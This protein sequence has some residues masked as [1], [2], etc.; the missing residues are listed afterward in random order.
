MPTPARRVT[1][2]SI[3]VLATVILSACSSPHAAPS[4]Q[5]TAGRSDA[6]LGGAGPAATNGARPA[7]PGVA[8]GAGA[9]KAAIATA[10]DALP[11]APGF[12]APILASQDPQSTFGLDVDTASYTYAKTQIDGGR[13]PA[14]GAVRP[15]EFVNAFR[16]D[17]P[18]PEGD[19]FTVTTDGAR[20]PGSGTDYQTDGMRL[21]RVGLQTRPDD[22][23][24]TPAVALTFVIDVSGSMGTPGKLDV[25]KEGL[26]ALVGSLRPDDS[27]AIVTFNASAHVI[28]PATYAAERS[29]LLSAIDGLHAAGR[30]NLAVGLTTG[31]RVARAGFEPE[32]TN[33]VVILSD[34]LA[35][36][37]QTSSSAIVSQV[38]AEADKQITLLGVGVGRTYGDALMESL[39]DHA[40]GFVVYVSSASQARQVFIDQLAATST[41]RALDA[42]AQVTFDP[43]AVISYRLIGYDD[44]AVAD[45]SF[46]DDRVDGGEVEAG[47]QVTAVYAVQLQPQAYGVVATVAVHWVDPLTHAPRD[48][49]S[50]VYADQLDISFEQAAAGLHVCYAAAY[51][52]EVLRGS[53]YGRDLQLD[54]LAAIAGEAAD[55]TEDPAVA[56]L[57][58]TIGRASALSGEG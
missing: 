23:Y 6:G 27:V 3:A 25:V 24:D 29:T 14:P 56:Q 51:F 11:P 48:A 47:Q 57:A 18:V 28:V 15:E 58:D 43:E 1:I 10:T 53:P 40:D 41:L 9:A 45:S 19:G 30:T 17:Y 13:L 33:R 38:R 2:A 8:P 55:E 39:A 5:G 22:G 34:G 7:A 46:T 16:Q 32:A 36:T 12:A 26:T 52:A 4:K 21:L 37:G 20:L 42:K 35:N 50:D 49:S 44:R 31:Y 54:D